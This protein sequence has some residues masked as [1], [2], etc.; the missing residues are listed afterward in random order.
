[1]CYHGLGQSGDIRGHVC[2]LTNLPRICIECKVSLIPK[3]TLSSVSC[4]PFN[5]MNSRKDIDGLS[6]VLCFGL[7]VMAGNRLRYTA[8]ISSW[9]RLKGEGGLCI[10]YGQITHQGTKK[11]VATKHSLEVVNAKSLVFAN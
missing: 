2:G 5:E 9:A 7:C 1:M 3:S 10:E 6:V 8:C 4:F 11:M